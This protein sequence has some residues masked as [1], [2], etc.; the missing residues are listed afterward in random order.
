MWGPSKTLVNNLGGS[1]EGFHKGPF[2]RDPITLSIDDDW[3]V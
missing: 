1:R 3:G 2:V